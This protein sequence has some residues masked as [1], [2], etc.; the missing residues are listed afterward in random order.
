[1]EVVKIVN[2]AFILVNFIDK[3][4]GTVNIIIKITINKYN[5]LQ[6]KQCVFFLGSSYELTKVVKILHVSI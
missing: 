6:K 3:K 1:M 2:K 5:I 4:L